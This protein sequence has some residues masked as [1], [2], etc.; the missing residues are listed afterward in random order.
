MLK[1]APLL[2]HGSVLKGSEHKCQSDE[3][4]K[5]ITTCIS[6]ICT[7]LSQANVTYWIDGG[8]LLG[9]IRN[10]GILRHDYDGDI[11]YLWI[12]RRVMENVLD[13]NYHYAIPNTDGV[14][15]DLYG[16]KITESRIVRRDNEQHQLYIQSILLALFDAKYTESTLFPVKSL[17]QYSR[18][19]A[20]S[21]WAHC[22]IPPDP[23]TYLRL[24]YSP[25]FMN[26][27][28]CSERS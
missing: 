3:Y 17:G 12:D 18:E 1:Y 14:Y 16:Y 5:S 28:S 10:K 7:Q 2:P 13:A 20:D 4:L 22:H 26:S 6:D 15:V 24:K 27:V 23:D 11:G 21:I 8:T 9:G 25:N 19:H